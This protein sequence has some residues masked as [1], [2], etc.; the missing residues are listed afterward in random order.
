MGHGSKCTLNGQE[1]TVRHKALISILLNTS[2]MNLNIDYKP[3]I[4]NATQAAQIIVC[5]NVDRPSKQNFNY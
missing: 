1:L 4:F 3:L 2:G 5:N